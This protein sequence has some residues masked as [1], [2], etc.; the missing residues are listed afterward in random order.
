V[1]FFTEIEKLIL[2]YIWKHKR[3]RIH[4]VIL[5][6][7]YNAGDTTIPDLKLYY[8]AITTK[9]SWYWHKNRH[10]NQCIRIEDPT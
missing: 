3:P 6:K 7:K 9:P 8:K 10:E 2:K 4:K 1:T 5:S